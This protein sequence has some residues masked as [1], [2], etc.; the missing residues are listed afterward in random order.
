MAS[1]FLLGHC[2]AAKAYETP[3]RPSKALLPSNLVNK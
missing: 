2:Q 3:Q 1:N